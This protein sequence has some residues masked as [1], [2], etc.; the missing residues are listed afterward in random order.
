MITLRQILQE[1]ETLSPLSPTAPRLAQIISDPDSSAEDVAEV[2]QFDQALTLDVLKFA[3]S[4][5][6]ASSRVIAT[7]KEAV[8]RIGGARILEWIVAQHVKN[9]FQIPLVAFGYSEKDLWRH[10]VASA[11]AAEQLASITSGR[12][13]GLSFTAALLHDIGKLI[14]GRMSASDNMDSVFW[15]MSNDNQKTTFEQ[16]ERSVYG[17]S[18]P[19]IGA[20]IAASWKLPEAIVQAIRHHHSYEHTD[21]PVTD[22]V[23]VSNLVARTIGVGIG[24]EGMC[25]SIDQGLATRTGISREQFELLC[26]RTSSRFDAVLLMYES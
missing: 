15:H 20:E 19:D 2:L 25:L 26:A 22:S 4:A 7:V 8:I 23:R 24:D 21:E 16:R 13:A 5:A 11:L 10:S 9:M 3:N 17:I 14:I 12:I 18:H 1:T 6:S